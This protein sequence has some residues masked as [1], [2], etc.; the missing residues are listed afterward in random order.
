[1]SWVGQIV[2]A[3]IGLGVAYFEA[4]A[5]GGDTSSATV[6][7]ALRNALDEIDKANAAR[8]GAA[9]AARR[10]PAGVL[11]DDDGFRRD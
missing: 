10:D 6:S 7:K 5:K 1:V 3:L 8:Q 2:L 9:D 11:R 4:R